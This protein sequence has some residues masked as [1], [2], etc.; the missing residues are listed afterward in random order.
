[1]MWNDFVAVTNTVTTTGG[2]ALW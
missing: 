2:L 1:L